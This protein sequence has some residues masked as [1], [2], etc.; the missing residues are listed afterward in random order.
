MMIWIY[1]SLI[2]I[3]A[4]I[5]S[6]ASVFYSRPKKEEKIEEPKGDDTSR[7]KISHTVYPD[8]RLEFNEFWKRIYNEVKKY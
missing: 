7:L 3:S 8:E 1:I 2:F 4:T 5:I 6:V